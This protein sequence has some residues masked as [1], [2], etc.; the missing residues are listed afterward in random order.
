MKLIEVVVLLGAHCIS[1]VQN[2]GAATEALKVQCAVVI[3]RD[4]SAGTV[5]IVPAG[6]STRPEVVAVLER[7]DATRIEQAYANP[8]SPA[9]AM[10]GK[11]PD[12][13]PLKP[14]DGAAEEPTG[15][16]VSASLPADGAGTPAKVQAAA[17]GRNAA[18][19]AKP[20]TTATGDTPSL[21]CIGEAKPK[22]YTNAEGRRKYRCVVA[23]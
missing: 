1:P 2:T 5:R 20:K 11:A 14:A 8:H 10:S 12:R 21:Q 4:T 13:K 3:E 18:P 16:A 17:P 7:R 22:W 19:K 9:P 15:E 6:A 23:D